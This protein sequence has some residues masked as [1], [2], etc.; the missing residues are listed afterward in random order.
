[1]KQQFEDAQNREAPQQTEGDI[2]AGSVSKKSI[3]ILRTKC[4]RAAQGSSNEDDSHSS[5]NTDGI[6]AIVDQHFAVIQEQAAKIEE[7]ENMMKAQEDKIDAQKVIMEAQEGTVLDLQAQLA[8]TNN[9]ITDMKSELN[10]IYRILALK[11]NGGTGMGKESKFPCLIQLF[12]Y[13]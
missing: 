10:Q 11:Q 8:T 12:K 3:V 4:Q 5:I 7:Y 2:V 9:A 13:L 6:K 1:M